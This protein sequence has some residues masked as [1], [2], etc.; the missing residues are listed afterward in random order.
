[1]ISIC[2]TDPSEFQA[3]SICDEFMFSDYFIDNEPPAGA[4][5]PNGLLVF[6]NT[7]T[8]LACSMALRCAAVSLTGAAVERF[9]RKNCPLGLIY[10]E[11]F[12]GKSRWRD[13]CGDWKRYED[14]F[15]FHLIRN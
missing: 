9:T 11:I 1:M 12:N 5:P 8:P 14:Q 4:D 3:H 6:F 7:R 2:L 13:H 10:A 15:G